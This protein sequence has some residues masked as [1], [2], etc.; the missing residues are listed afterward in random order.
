M[1]KFMKEWI[2][3]GLVGIS[4]IT[5]LALVS[6]AVSFVTGWNSSDVFSCICSVL[7]SAWF[8]FWFLLM[9]LDSKQANKSDFQQ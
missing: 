8:G 3:N 9:Y 6:Y 5:V 4:V 7:V 2:I 1:K